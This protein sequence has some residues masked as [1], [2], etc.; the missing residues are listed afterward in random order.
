MLKPDIL[1]RGCAMERPSDLPWEDL[2]RLLL[3]LHER[4]EQ[5]EGVGGPSDLFVQEAGQK[6][7]DPVFGSTVK[8][9]ETKA[10]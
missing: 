6:G 8:R 9:T 4:D 3:Y 5:E 1:L 7:E 10:L 2:L